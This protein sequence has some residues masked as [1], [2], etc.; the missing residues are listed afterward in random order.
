MN[1]QVA[2]RLA[3][4]SN[5]LTEVSQPVSMAGFNAAQ[6]DAT[7]YQISGTTPK[8]S[9]QLQVSNHLENWS[10]RGTAHD[11]GASPESKLYTKETGIAAAYCRLHY[12]LSGTS[13]KAVLAASINLST[14]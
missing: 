7:L 4:D 12:T 2:T 11:S 3:L 1:Q 13:P 10:D 9:F 6:W 5:T 14:Q 8:V